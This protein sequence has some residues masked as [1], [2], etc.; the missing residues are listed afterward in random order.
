MCADWWSCS[1]WVFGRLVCDRYGVVAIG[2][3]GSF[4]WDSVSPLLLLG[5]SCRCLGS[6]VVVVG[7]EL[8]E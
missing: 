8:L 7:R 2:T 6:L 3:Y 5:M 1:S 4:L